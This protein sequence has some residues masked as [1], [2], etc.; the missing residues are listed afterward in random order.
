MWEVRIGERV[1]GRVSPSSI[2]QPPA[3]HGVPALRSHS[4]EKEGGVGV[5]VGSAIPGLGEDRKKLETHGGC[6]G[7]RQLWRVAPS[8]G[9]ESVRYDRSALCPPHLFRPSL[10]GWTGLVRIGCGSRAGMGA[11][12]SWRTGRVHVFWECVWVA[13]AGSTSKR[14]FLRKEIGDRKWEIGPGSNAPG[15]WSTG[16]GSGAGV[17]WGKSLACPAGGGLAHGG[18]D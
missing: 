17:A 8:H 4:W 14:A 11:E 16:H 2:P 7:Q 12:G 13:S 6:G 18:V 3:G 5:R 1:M 15:P 9:T 10:Q